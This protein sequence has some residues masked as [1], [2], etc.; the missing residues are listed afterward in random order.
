[1]VVKGGYS[2]YIKKGS[3]SGMVGKRSND[4]HAPSV[5]VVLKGKCSEGSNVQIEG[6][7]ND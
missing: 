7:E 1:M 4:D 6:V 5:K 2:E 3:K